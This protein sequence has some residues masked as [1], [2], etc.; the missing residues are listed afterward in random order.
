MPT[1]RCLLCGREFFLGCDSAGGTYK[2]I[3]T[4]ICLECQLR[5]LKGSLDRVEEEIRRT[6]SEIEALGMACRGAETPEEKAKRDAER[7]RAQERLEHLVGIRD[8]LREEIRRL[9]EGRG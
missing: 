5:E 8:F 9:G 1:P 7:R 3:F 4:G 2:V 6:V